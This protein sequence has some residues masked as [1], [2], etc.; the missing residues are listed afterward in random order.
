MIV[1]AWDLPEEELADA[2]M[3]QAKLMSG[4]PPE[5]ILEGPSEIL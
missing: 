2:V 4:M 3:D 1:S 5:E